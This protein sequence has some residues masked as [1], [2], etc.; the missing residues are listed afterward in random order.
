MRLKGGISSSFNIVNRVGEFSVQRQG[1]KKINLKQ[2][3]M[4]AETRR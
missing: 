2:S 1:I 4:R 3:F